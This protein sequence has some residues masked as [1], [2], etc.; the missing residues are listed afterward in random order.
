MAWSKRSGGLGSARP[1]QNK[2]GNVKTCGYD[3]RKEAE[4]ARVLHL[5]EK[6]G[7]IRDLKEQVPYTV[8]PAQYIDGKCVERACIYK[9]DFD[10][11]VAE[12]FEHVVEDAKG[13]RT[14][15][16][17]IKRKLMLKVF[18]IRIREV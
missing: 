16:Y 15:D 10:Y 4:R 7:K 3:S 18:G 9:A 11:T 6:A 13:V 12:T 8:I 2:Y 1:T 5:L 17:I 14:K